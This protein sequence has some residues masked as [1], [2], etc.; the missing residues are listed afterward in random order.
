MSDGV[1]KEALEQLEHANTVAQMTRWM[2]SILTLRLEQYVYEH[3]Q[4]SMDDINAYYLQIQKKLYSHILP[5]STGVYEW[6]GDIYPW[7]Y[8]VYSFGHIIAG[9]I[10]KRIKQYG[11]RSFGSIR[12]KQFGSWLKEE[13]FRPGYAVPW[14]QLLFQTTGEEFTPDSY[15]IFDEEEN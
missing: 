12:N 4:S 13:L 6:A 3:P 1:S 11:E 9:H 15:S 5:P 2:T 7:K 10:A 8:P 14:R